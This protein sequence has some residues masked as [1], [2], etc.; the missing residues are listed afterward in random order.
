MRRGLAFAVVL[1]LLLAAPAAADVSLDE[2]TIPPASTNAGGHPDVTI[3]QRMSYTTRADDVKD[4]FVRLAPGL[5]GNPQNADFCGPDQFAADTCPDGS[6]IGTVTAQVTIYTLIPLTPGVPDTVPGAAYNLPPEGTEPARVG[7]ILRPPIGDKVFLES[8]AVLTLGPD[9]YGLETN[10]TDQPRTAITPLDQ[11]QI[12][13]VSLTFVGRGSEGAFMRMPTACNTA[14]SVG[15]ASSYDSAAVSEKTSAFTPTDCATLGF[16]PRASGSVGAPGLTDRS[17]NPPFTSTLRFNPEEAALKSAT[18]TLPHLLSPN[19]AA[20]GNRCRAPQAATGACPASSRVGT[21]TIDSP[22]QPAPVRGPIFLAENSSNPLP[23][24]I[25]LLPAPVGVRLDATIESGN[26]G[27]RNIFASNPDLPVRTFTLQFDGGP[28]GVVKLTDDLCDEKS[29]PTIDVNL[30]SHSGKRSQFKTRLATPGCDP[31][32][33]GAIRRR[34]TRA[35]LVSRLT[36]AREGPSM[37]A[38]TLRLPKA[39]RTGRRRPLVYV[40][41]RRLRPDSRK[42]SLSIRFPS[43]VRGA[44]IVWRGLRASRRLRTFTHLGISITDTRGTTTR[45]RTE[46]PVRGKAPRRR[47]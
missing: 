10:F 16:N 7:L 31:R 17:D 45:L 36:A 47:R 41:T 15:R 22:L 27:T 40:G 3:V 35:R 32:A 29:D 21:A 37:T 19:Q 8:A 9:G 42:R 6:Q 25:V 44:V 1:P 5:L 39:L 26:F 23:G 46:V 38:A 4:S 11:V 34:G 12:D 20:A 30:L 43:E 13:E 28:N 24:L 2:F 33:S 14:T 18:V